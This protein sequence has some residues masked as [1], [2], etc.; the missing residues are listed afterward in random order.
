MNAPYH[1]I[2]R[3]HTL[4]AVAL[5]A[6]AC[7]SGCKKGNC[8]SNDPITEPRG[9]FEVLGGYPP[10]VYACGPK[11]GRYPMVALKTTKIDDAERTLDDFATS[12]GWTKLHP[13]PDRAGFN[14]ALAGS[15]QNRVVYKKGQSLLL[16]TLELEKW[17]GVVY[18]MHSV[19][20][21]KA[22]SLDDR[23]VCEKYGK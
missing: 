1:V 4:L 3:P 22:T 11:D 14:A 16:G 23:E 15:V 2:R 12:K 6:S 19:D 20:C 21:T 8:P 13:S 9:G 18:T 7:V 10:G 17:G 5:L